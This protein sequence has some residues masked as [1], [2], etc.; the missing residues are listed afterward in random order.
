MFRAYCALL[1]RQTDWRLTFHEV[2]CLARRKTAYASAVYS[3]FGFRM[4]N[5]GPSQLSA[6]LSVEQRSETGEIYTRAAC[7][8]PFRVLQKFR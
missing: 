1:G 5:V 2:V 8:D 3:A 6:V 7:N 4:A